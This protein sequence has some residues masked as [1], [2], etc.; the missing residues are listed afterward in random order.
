MRTLVILVLLFAGMSPALASVDHWNFRVLLDGREIGH[1]R[2]TLQPVGEQLELQSIAQFDLRFLFLSAWRYSHQAVERW[3]GDCLSS[4]E[5]LTDTNGKHSAVSAR[6]RDGRLAVERSDGREVYEGCIMTFAY[7]NPRVLGAHRLLNSQTGELIPVVITSLGRESI[8][9]YGISTVAERHRIR[10][11]GVEID[12]WYAN[13][14]WV[15][16]KAL[17][18]GGRTLRYELADLAETP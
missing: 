3:D 1:H 17:A 8:E 5:S 18:S 4:I 10:G 11:P 14:E 7:W 13:G 6:S 2:F 16:L 15:A 9:V 12:L